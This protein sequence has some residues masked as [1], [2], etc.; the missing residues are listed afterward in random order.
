MAD[1]TGQKRGQLTFITKTGERD[2][3][4]RP[5]YFV[6]CNCGQYTVVNVSTI[7]Q[8]VRRGHDCSCGHDKIKDYSGQRF[9][10][11]TAIKIV[12]RNKHSRALW[13]CECDCG[14][15][16]EYDSNQL[17]RG[18]VTSCG[19]GRIERA[20]ANLDILNSIQKRENHPRWKG[21]HISLR[22]ALRTHKV[23]LDWRTACFIRDN[24]RCVECGSTKRIE[25]DHII[26]FKKIQKDFNLKTV[27]DALRCDILWDVNNG[28][29]L[30]HKHH[31]E[32]PT[33]GRKNS[34]VRLSD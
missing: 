1:L 32:T 2:K 15:E 7:N 5:F 24:R 6:R 21:G 23:Y 4:R 13:L 19:C 16:V 33:W 34:N 10:K 31:V 11:L 28:R 25:C 8:A 27:E 20:R 3:S 9:G 18:N 17:Q 14:Q 30:C 26:P 12:G 22:D 29:T